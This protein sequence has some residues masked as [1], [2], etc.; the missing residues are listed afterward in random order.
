MNIF[1]LDE[2]PVLAAQYLCDKHVIKMLLESFQLLSTVHRTWNNSDI[3]YKPTHIKHP[4]TIWLLQSAS[5]YNWL[6]KHTEAMH[7][8]YVN[9]YQKHHK[10]YLQLHR[11]TKSPPEQLP[12]IGLT[13]F[14]LAMPEVYKRPDPVL[15]YRLY[16]V[17]DKIRICHWKPPSQ[18]PPWFK[19]ILSNL[20]NLLI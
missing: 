11:L 14:V 16:Y 19:E 4:C 2:D 10:S 13:P 7:Q 17:C 20:D 5:N 9:R 6:V 15:S 18:E 12:D 8:E 1:I 3:F